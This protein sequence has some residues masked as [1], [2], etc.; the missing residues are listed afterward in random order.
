MPSYR[1]SSAY[2]QWRLTATSADKIELA[3]R[4]QFFP[5]YHLVHH[6]DVDLGI[7]R[8][9]STDISRHTVLAYPR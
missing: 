1:S 7:S 9:T 2:G 8:Y 4:P 3:L 6:Q 5:V